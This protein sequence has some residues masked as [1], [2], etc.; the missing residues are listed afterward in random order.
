MQVPF[1]EVMLSAAEEFFTV[2]KLHSAFVVTPTMIT[3]EMQAQ[4]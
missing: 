2:I 3:V 1:Q 4:E